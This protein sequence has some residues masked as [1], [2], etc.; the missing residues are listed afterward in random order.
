[1][2]YVPKSIC[3]QLKKICKEDDGSFRGLGVDENLDRL[4]AVLKTSNLPAD[5]FDALMPLKVAL[6]KAGEKE[7]AKYVATILNGL[8]T[9]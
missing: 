8:I 4:A 6:E 9:P 5:I 2:K 1:M 7:K 3:S